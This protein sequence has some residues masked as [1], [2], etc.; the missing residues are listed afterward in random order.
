MFNLVF[1]SFDQS[2]KLQINSVVTP[3]DSVSVLD[4]LD[5]SAHKN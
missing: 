5:K 4:S 3:N 2:N 1:L